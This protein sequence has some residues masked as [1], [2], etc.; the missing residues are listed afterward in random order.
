MENPFPG[1]EACME[2]MR[3]RDPLTREE[4]YHA[5]LP[6]AAEFLPRLIE[7]FQTERDHGLKCWLFELIDEAKSP[8]AFPLFLEHLS[9]GDESLSARAVQGLHDLGTEEARQA[10]RE[11]GITIPPETGQRVR[12]SGWHAD[13]NPMHFIMIVR[14]Y[15]GVDLAGA[16][17]YLDRV[18][19]GEAV[20]LTPFRPD[21]LQEFADKLRRYNVCE[22]VR[23]VAEE[24]P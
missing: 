6:R 10:L 17:A 1:F 2:R 13:M 19:G 23:V 21:T 18:R 15:T 20:D 9:G 3:E 4:G 8:D 24:T 7:A 11:A 22:T 14:E 16:K 12:M 5:L